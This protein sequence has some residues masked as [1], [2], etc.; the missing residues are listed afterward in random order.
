MADNPFIVATIDPAPVAEQA[1]SITFPKPTGLQDGDVLA[2]PIRSQAVRNGEIVLPSGWARGGLGTVP[3][4]RSQ[5]MFYKPI[6]S[7]AAE[8][9]TSYTFSGLSTST[10]RI[11]GKMRVIRGA[12]LA[13][14]NDGGV[15]YDADASLPATTAGG[16]PA[17]ALALFTG[18][19]TAGVSVVP[20][21]PPGNGWVQEFVAQT[22]GGSSPAPVTPNSTTTG[23]RTGMAL[24][25]KR[26]AD[27]T[28]LAALTNTWSTGG[29]PTDPKSALWI[30]R[31]K[32]DVVVP[33]GFNSV[34]EMRAC[35]GATWAHRGGSASYI[36]HSLAAYAAA[37]ARGYGVLEISLQ[38][39]SDGVWFALHDVTLAGITGNPALTQDVRTMTWAQV[40]QYQMSV[41]G[42][43]TA[44]FMRWSDFI[45][46]G[47]GNTHVLVID[48]KNSIDGN[49]AEFFAM[50]K[51]AVDPSRVIMKW[52]GGLTSF[53]TA[54][55]AEGFATAGYWYQGDYDNGNLAA[56]TPFWDYLGMDYTATTAWTGLGN[57]VELAAAQGKKV[58]GHITPTQ[59]AY[60]TAMAKG[61]DMVQVSGVAVV[62]PVS[63]S[64]SALTLPA[65][66]AS[67]TGTSTPPGVTGSGSLVFPA[68]TASGVGETS[69]PV[70]NGIGALTLPALTAVGGGSSAAP[71]YT[72]TGELT[73]PAL[74][75]VGLGEGVPPVFVATGALTLP[76]L[77]A[78]GIG[79][80][81][82]PAPGV[83]GNGSLLLPALTAGGSG[84]SS[85]PAYAGAAALTLPALRAEGSGVV[86]PPGSIGVGVLTL[87]ALTVSGQGNVG[88]EVAPFPEIRTLEPVPTP[89]RTLTPLIAVRTLEDA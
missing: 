72:G 80:V 55:K 62:T 28:A 14:L 71:E 86:S 79:T 42:K 85:P 40:N 84:T 68:L 53:A 16:L 19:F 88:D 34:A 65:L 44:P 36:E 25:S 2:V 66:T 76:A 10:S 59:T 20:T 45:A 21:T 11:I 9:A 67:G 18:E 5:G 38:R 50:V 26:L 58:W 13:H 35:K 24:F 83:I 39:T 81:V 78:V 43:G 17:L 27:S 29:S 3:N 48:P 12:D 52:S 22:A 47:Y 30:I 1:A 57:I 82:D 74:Q 41:P 87:P 73:L 75:A 56:Q 8:T 70:S 51:A 37:A 77:T 7:V 6:P 31:G 4:D 61:A 60:D 64:T 15:G 54:A 23:S 63:W 46:A 33:R 69:R 89:A 49:Q 32:A